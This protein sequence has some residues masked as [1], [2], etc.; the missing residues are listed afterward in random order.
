MR[1]GLIILVAALATLQGCA[2]D[3]VPSG[4][5]TSCEATQVLPAAVETDILLVI[6]DS[7][8]MAEEQVNLH[9]NLA[10]FIDALAASP[11]S[12]HFRIGVTSTSVAAFGATTTTG[13]SY[14]GGPSRGVPYPAGALVAI[15]QDAT[16]AGVTGKLLYD[17]VAS[18][19]TG[20]WWGPRILDQGSPTLARDFKANVLLGTSGSGKEQPW[21]AARLALSD[22]LADAN[23]GFLR[24]GARLAVIFLTDEDDCSDTLAPFAGT[25]DACHAM[26]TKDAAPPILDTPEELAAF[27][28]GPIDGEQREVMVGAIAGLDPVTLAPSCSD[29]ALCSDTACST[30]FDK[31]DRFVRLQAA[32]G[33]DLMRLGSICDASFK[34]TLTRFAVA[35]MPS[36]LP[37][38]GT[39]ADWRMLVVTVVRADGTTVGCGVAAAGTPGQGGADAV[40][41]P[42]GFGQPAQLAFQNR[43]TLGLGDRIDVR[44]V[45]AN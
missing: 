45:C 6:D 44:V 42:P 9:D 15:E 2:C 7:L 38:Q 5:V 29:P 17:P 4:A 11:V 22:R 23:A 3:T 31:G 16:G 37:L 1:S 8:S 12:N 36:T 14:G 19:A 20:G 30:A 32:L 41:T 27:L 26:A 34:D 10:A 40:Y 43:C 24:P 35:L 28:K 39:P 33:S 18:P 21:R 13:L 25:N